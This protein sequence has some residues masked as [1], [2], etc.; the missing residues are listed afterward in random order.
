VD[1]M[2]LPSNVEGPRGVSVRNGTSRVWNR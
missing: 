1:E 2:L